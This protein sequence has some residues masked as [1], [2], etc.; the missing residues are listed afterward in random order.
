MAEGTD[1]REIPQRTSGWATTAADVLA[2]ARL[3]PN[4]ISVGSVLVAA[5]GAAAM[6]ISTQTGPGWRTALLIT[7]ALCIPIRLVLNMLDGM[8]A[9]EKGLHSPVGDLY[10]EVPDRVA[11]ALF[12]G[13]AG[14]AT[15]GLVL[16]G[17]IDVGIVLGFLAAILAVLTAY[18][19]ALGASLGTGQFFDG[20]LAKQHRMWVLMAGLLLAAAERW[21]PWAQGAALFCALALIALGS[22]W[23]CA[24]RLRRISAALRR[25]NQPAQP[26]AAE[27]GA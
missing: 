10:N 12:I 1:R 26:P 18:I 24:R 7:A 21:L 22:L 19:R 20:P 9:V 5:A 23:T 16:A 15:A 14:V 17:G 4:Q 3:T 27:P 8:L 2:A 13:S 6:V 25:A 11:D